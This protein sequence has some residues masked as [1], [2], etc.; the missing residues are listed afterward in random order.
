M[1]IS[2]EKSNSRG[3]SDTVRFNNIQIVVSLNLVVKH[4]TDEQP[5]QIQDPETPF[6]PRKKFGSK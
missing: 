5:W 4:F 6:W 2:L 1:N 3:V